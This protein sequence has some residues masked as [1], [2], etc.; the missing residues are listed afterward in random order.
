MK[1]NKKN[2]HKTRYQGILAVNN[3][4]I[5]NLR[6]KTFLFMIDMCRSVKKRERQVGEQNA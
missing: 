4:K 3:K 2:D 6:G 1:K 5:V